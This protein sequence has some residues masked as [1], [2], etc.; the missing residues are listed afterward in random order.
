[1]NENHLQRVPLER[2][3]PPNLDNLPIELIL[4]ITGHLSLNEMKDL[5]LVC[6]SLRETIDYQ[7]VQELIVFNCHKFDPVNSWALTY[8]PINPE[9]CMRFNTKRRFFDCELFSFKCLKRLKIVSLVQKINFEFKDLNRFVRLEHLDLKLTCMRTQDEHLSLPELRLFSLESYKPIHLTCNLPNLQMFRITQSIEH[10][11][12]LHDCDGLKYLEMNSYHDKVQHFKGLEVFKLICSH[13]IDMNILKMLP[14][15]KELHF[16]GS[17][18]PLS[19]NCFN[20]FYDQIAKL[21]VYI[22]KQRS[23]LER[24]VKLFI[25][26]VE[27]DGEREFR[28]YDFKQLPIYLLLGNF[29]QL[30]DRLPF[31]TSFN[32]NELLA[33][34][35]EL[36]GSATVP[37]NFFKK[38][39][40]IQK[41]RNTGPIAKQDAL[42]DFLICCPN[43]NELV[44]HNCGLNAIFYQQLFVC[45]P[46]LNRLALR[47][48]ADCPIDY[49]FIFNLKLLRQFATDQNVSMQSILAG[50]EKLEFLQSVSFRNRRDY[51]TIGRHDRV[52]YLDFHEPS[53]PEFNEK[54]KQVLKKGLAVLKTELSFEELSKECRLLE[55][56]GLTLF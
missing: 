30:A 32:Y 15:L 6:K 25:F 55:D 56:R 46:T 16:N 2:A 13:Q 39:N 41:V 50:L 52:Y 3:E 36:F 45:C 47:E 9:F 48:E 26:G 42:L 49:Q 12:F 23:K 17:F 29:D 18:D 5:R 51:V 44:L 10:I 8:E 40:N 37:E 7:L 21:T 22:H 28:D 24:N 20:S 14:D 54:G 31:V 35:Q 38:M 34:L 1:M 53:R 27:F 19:V 33:T 43:L 4:I 11:D